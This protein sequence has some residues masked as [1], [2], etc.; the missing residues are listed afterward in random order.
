M[1]AAAGLAIIGAR[2]RTLDADA[3]EATAVAVADGRILAVGSNAEVRAACDGG[4]ELID[5]RGMVLVP[6]LVDAHQHP[7]VG[8]ETTSG[9]DLSEACTVDEVCTALRRARRTTGRGEWLRG[10]SLAYEAFAGERL[11]AELIE[12]AVDGAPAL[13]TF[14]DLHTALAS[15]S[16]LAAAGI[17]G[18]RVFEDA[19]E[20]VCEAGV[21]TGELREVSAW[22]LVEAAA[23][24]RTTAERRRL[25]ARALRD[26]NAVGITGIHAMD[27]SPETLEDYAALEADG[28]LTARVVVPFNVDPTTPVQEY[29]ALIAARNRHGRLWRAGAAKFFID[30]VVES[31]T[32]WLFEPDAN[33]GGGDAFWPDVDAYREAV[34]IFDAAGFQCI[35]HAIG[36]RAVHAALDAYRHAAEANGARDR[37]H[38]VEHLETL[39]DEDLA[40]L[41][42]EG[43]VAS[44]Q[45]IHTQWIAAD[46]SDPWSRALGPERARRGFRLADIRRSGAVLALGSDWPVAGYDPRQGMAW[47]RLRRPAGMRGAAR[48]NAEQALSGLEA[49]EGYTTQAALAVGEEGERGRIRAGFHADLTAFADDP[50][51]C[52]ADDLPELPVTLTVVGGRIVHRAD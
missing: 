42:A 7:I 26:Q 8:A 18:P 9:I 4:T 43:V 48:F 11:S 37:R 27:G 28:A 6:G 25:A 49:L 30:G 39:T 23:P 45:A 32:A 13:L 1:A 3:P 34:R 20:V 46:G 19:S 33:G 21:P 38:R 50:V 5:G 51:E 10:H 16:A 44:Q 22:A 24:T 52:R 14:F 35:T 40:R 17:T 12:E 41:V 2:V 15:R 47:A 31:G 29:P 36:D